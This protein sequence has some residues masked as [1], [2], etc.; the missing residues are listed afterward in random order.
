M[1]RQRDYKRNNIAPHKLFQDI[2]E[3]CCGR[4]QVSSGRDLAQLELAS[5][6][7]KNV[8]YLL[9]LFLRHLALR[10]PP[11][12]ELCLLEMW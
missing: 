7:Q 10:G 5:T 4:D 1:V 2:Q 11:L 6:G 8:K 9:F 12:V 3:P